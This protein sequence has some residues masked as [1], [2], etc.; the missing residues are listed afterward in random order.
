VGSFEGKWE[1]GERETTTIG[2]KK[3][4]HDLFKLKKK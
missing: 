1:E 4:N 3:K 2:K